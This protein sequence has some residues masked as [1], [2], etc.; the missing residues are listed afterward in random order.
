VQNIL[1]RILHFFVFGGSEWQAMR[2]EL[3]DMHKHYG[4]IKA[5]NGINLTVEEGTIHGILGENGAGKSTL[6]K[7]LAGFIPKTS[8]DIIIDGKVRNFHTP[9]E[10]SRQGIGMLYQEPLDYPTLS[11]LENF[12][13]GQAKGFVNK[14]NLFR[15]KF[16]ELVEHFNFTLNPEDT[17]KHLTIGERQQLEMLRLLALGIEILILDEPTTGISDLQK[18]ALFNALRKL[19]SEGKSV[20][21]VSHKLKD[22]E[23]LCDRVTVLREGEVTGSMENP[24]NANELLAMMFGEPPLPSTRSPVEY[25]QTVLSMKDISGMGGRTGLSHSSVSTKEG[26]MIGLAGLEGSGQGVFL[27]IAAGITKPT[28][29]SLHLFGEDMEG[30]NLHAFKEAGVVFL[31]ASRLEEGLMPDLSIQEHFALKDRQSSFFVKWDEA[32]EEARLKT[33][34]FRV[35]GTP[36]TMAEALSGGNQQRLMLSLLSKE[37]TLLLLEQPTRGLDVESAN[38]VWWHLSKYCLRKTSII[39]SSADLDEIMSIADRILVFFDGMIIKDVRREETN[40]K[41]LAE[42]IA[43]KR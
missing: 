37:S 38:W 22:S 13:I 3:R 33:E 2:I 5:N 17:V 34:K 14:S 23:A 27:R 29:G 32:L 31:P 36:D 6:M 10:A 7:V 30:K 42:A 24:Y 26:E 9:A 18:E 28:G 40:I 11:V 41:E 16:E 20:I 1:R 43:G 4:S 25:G 39:F 35:K 8:G 15:E 21:L 12:M 19:A